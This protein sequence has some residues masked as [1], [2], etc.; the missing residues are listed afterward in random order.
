M[1]YI[2]STTA[3]LPQ[4]VL[5]L[6]EWREE[7]LPFDLIH[8]IQGQDQCLSVECVHSVELRV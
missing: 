6:L 4:L 5:S 3:S 7:C 1:G 2:A 8:N